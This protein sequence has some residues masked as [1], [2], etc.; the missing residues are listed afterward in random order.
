MTT[1]I[2]PM[3]PIAPLVDQMRVI[4]RAELPAPRMCQIE[5][6]DDGTFTV[7]SNHPMGSHERQRIRYDRTTSEIL[8]E[9]L[10]S[11]GTTT[12]NLTGGRPF[13]NRTC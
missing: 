1:A 12:I 3:E 7:E 6:F 9:H 8:W 5:L 13:A 10:E 2:P 4:A 11:G